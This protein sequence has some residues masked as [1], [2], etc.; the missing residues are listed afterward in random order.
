M[1]RRYA[2]KW[3][4]FT[5]PDPSDG[6][7][8]LTDPQ[9][10][11]RYAYV[12][13]DPVNFVDPSGLDP[14]DD[15]PAGPLDTV[16]INTQA[17]RPGLAGSVLASMANDTGILIVD[18]PAG[19]E[20]GGGGG[21]DPQDPLP[22]KT[23]TP[24]PQPNPCGDAAFAAI[25]HKGFKTGRAQTAISSLLSEAAK[26]GLTAAQAAY[27]L[28]TAEHESNMGNSVVEDKAFAA[29]QD[30]EG[31]VTYRGRG[32]IHLTHKTNYQRWG[33]A[34]NPAEAARPETAARIAVQG[35]VNGSF[36]GNT[37]AGSIPINGQPNFYNA[38]WIVIGQTR[39]ERGVARRLEG[40]ANDYLAALNG[41][42]WAP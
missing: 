26:S 21:G 42:G 27:V 12:Q 31:G 7:Y 9:S 33:V 8:D 19:G 22:A 5:Q 39:H 1:M 2:G 24:T 15:P 6:S 30:Y 10:F 38:R 17:P 36:T 37:L 13:N 25:H 41:C 40:Y 34:N 11:N 18:P 23:P 14:D 29:T 20:D 16:V 35:M 28:A 3:H 32:Y 4:R